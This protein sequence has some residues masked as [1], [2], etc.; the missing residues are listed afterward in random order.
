MLS[1][2]HQ[3]LLPLRLYISVCVLS[4]FG[5]VWLSCNPMDCSPSD[6]SVHGI[7]YAIITGV[8]CRFL[9]QGIFL[10]Q[11]S[12]PHFL[13]LLHWQVSSLPLA[14][15]GKPNITISLL[16]IGSAPLFY[17][18]SQIE[19]SS[20]DKTVHCWLPYRLIC[21]SGTSTA[22]TPGVAIVNIL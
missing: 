13:C 6:S 20:L 22:N 8:G 4:C 10:T 11:G 7:P 1:L 2:A 15:S 19:T 5:C 17:L 16:K 12:N 14:P 18:L 21:S 3:P 9:L